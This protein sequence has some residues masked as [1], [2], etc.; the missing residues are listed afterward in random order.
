MTLVKPAAVYVKLVAAAVV[1]TLFTYPFFRADQPENFDIWSVLNW[2]MAAALAVVL[3]TTWR[4]RSAAGA[5][6]KNARAMFVFAVAVT[7]AFVPNWFADIVDSSDNL[8]MWYL[9][10]TALPILLWTEGHRLWKSV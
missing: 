3:L 4:R 1:T 5:H 8:T 10:D 7:I 2:F 9:I 6:D